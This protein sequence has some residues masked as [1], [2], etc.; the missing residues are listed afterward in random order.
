MA[1]DAPTL[2]ESG[3]KTHENKMPPKE[4]TK[5][6]VQSF[7]H[8]RPFSS[9]DPITTVDNKFRVKCTKLAC[10]NVGVINLQT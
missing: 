6:R 3:L 2:Y 1:V 9:P 7:Q 4:D 8:P 10:K 5:Y